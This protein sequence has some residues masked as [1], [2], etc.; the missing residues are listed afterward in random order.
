GGLSGAPLADRSI[1]VLKLLKAHVDNRIDI[2]SVGGV[3][4]KADVEARLKAGANL[5]QGYTGF[6]YAGP[7]WAANLNA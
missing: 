6:I 3:E 1:A 5:V 7:L 2:I 4:T